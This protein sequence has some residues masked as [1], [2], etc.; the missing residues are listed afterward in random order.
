[1]LLTLLML[2]IF[3]ACVGL[4]YPEGMWSNALRLINVVTAALLAVNYFE[5]VAYWLEGMMPS[6]TYFWD[7]IALWGVFAVSMMVFRLI[8]DRVSHVKVRFLILADRIGSG[9]FAAWVGWVMVCFTMMTLHAAPM[10]RVFLSGG[11]QAESNMVVGLA[12]D[13]QWLGFVQKMSL[14]TFSR[15]EVNTFDPQAEYM[16]KCASRRA[17]LGNHMQ[18]TDA[19]LVRP[20]NVPH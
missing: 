3:A 9:F 12:P 5:P 4:L 11:F 17:N 8:T 2:V 6:F 1:M 7:Y 18:S 13:R 19:I 14:G 10:E 16:L 20:E 15:S